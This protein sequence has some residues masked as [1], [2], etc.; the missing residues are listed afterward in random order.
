M[1]NKYHSVVLGRFTY[2]LHLPLIVSYA[3]ITAN[4]V[5]S[6][7]AARKHFIDM[8]RGAFWFNVAWAS[9]AIAMCCGVFPSAFALGNSLHQLSVGYSIAVGIVEQARASGDI[10]LLF[11]L[12][13]PMA[14][15]GRSYHS[16]GTQVVD[17]SNI[18]FYIE[19]AAKNNVAATI[20]GA[21]LYA[22]YIAFF[23]VA[24]ILPAVLLTRYI[25]RKVA[26]L[27]KNQGKACFMEGTPPHTE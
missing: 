13:E 14:L 11:A 19:I 2:L 21:A 17:L 3:L 7:P 4:I 24:C 8:E 1:Q 16:N 22:A 12:E 23:L 20:S 26:R 27:E 6:A 18:S 25:N 5:A 9:I 10:T 15:L